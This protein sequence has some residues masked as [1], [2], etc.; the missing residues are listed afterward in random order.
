ME[1]Y[2]DFE[3]KQI[4]RITN[5]AL[6]KG[7]RK[8]QIVSAYQVSNANFY[9]LVIFDYET[10]YVLYAFEFKMKQEIAKIDIDTLLSIRMSLSPIDTF[11]ILSPDIQSNPIDYRLNYK[12]N[13]LENVDLKTAIRP[14]NELEFVRKLHADEK[15]ANA[16][17]S[18]EL[19]FRTVT[20]SIM[21]LNT[22]VFMANVFLDFKLTN[23]RLIL[24][25]M[26]DGSA[27]ISFFSY[28]KIGDMIELHR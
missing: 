9:D 27:Y 6:E 17:K 5:I 20:I 24:L 22:I 14:P 15:K 8:E 4:E 28:I 11:L 12:S 1:K 19:T 23:E 3:K 10:N 18:F 21:V 26:I 13:D 25:G 16:I 2:F 7:F